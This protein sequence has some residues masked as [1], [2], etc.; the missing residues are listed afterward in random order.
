[1]KEI[2]LIVRKQKKVILN[3]SRITQLH[4]INTLETAW[5]WLSY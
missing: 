2:D 3:L 4:I 5:K 1:M